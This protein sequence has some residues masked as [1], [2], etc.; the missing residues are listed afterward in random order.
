MPEWAKKTVTLLKMQI[1]ELS[2]ENSELRQ[3]LCDITEDNEEI[4]NS[5][6]QLEVDLHKLAQYGRRETLQI[7][8]IPNSV[9]IKDLEPYVINLLNKIG[10]ADLESYDV[11]ACHRLYKSYDKRP[12]DVVI[13]FVN[14][15]DVFKAHK[16][17]WK[18]RSMSQFKNIRFVENLCPYYRKMLNECSKFKS[19]GKINSYWTYNGKLFIKK[20]EDDERGTAIFHV[21]ELDGFVNDENSSSEEELPDND[22]NKNKNIANVKIYI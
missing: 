3:E 6:Y 7:K 8:G 11:V 4:C 18:L 15:K 5:I 16:N 9:K 1:D 19:E 14:R 21:D 22:N 13:R 2:V 20:E 17:K 12:A 10:L